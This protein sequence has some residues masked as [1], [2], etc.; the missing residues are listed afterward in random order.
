LLRTTRIVERVAA[1]PEVPTIAESGVSGFDV[2]SWF[3]VFLPA[4]TPR[5]IVMKMNREISTGYSKTRKCGS[6]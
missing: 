2:S 5:T 6:A 1:L 3:G 4:A